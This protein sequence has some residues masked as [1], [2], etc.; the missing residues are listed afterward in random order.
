MVKSQMLEIVASCLLPGFGSMSESPKKDC[1]SQA[2]S[3]EESDECLTETLDDDPKLKKLA[4][5]NQSLSF[6]L[7]DSQEFHQN[8]LKVTEKDMDQ[9]AQIED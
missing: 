4:D 1:M 3:I 6:E 7:Q 8:F 2:S 9:D 5:N